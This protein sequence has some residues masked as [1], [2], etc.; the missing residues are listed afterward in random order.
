MKHFLSV[1]LAAL[2]LLA[3]LSGSVLA[4]P[5]SDSATALTGTRVKSLSFTIPVPA[6]QTPAAL[7]LSAPDYLA[8]ELSW[9]CNGAPMSD[10]APFADGN[11]YQ[12]IIELSALNGYTF[13]GSFVIT[14]NDQTVPSFGTAERR[15][16]LVDFLLSAG[17]CVQ[18]FDPFSD[19]KLSDYFYN[20]VLWAYTSDP[21]IT[22]GL[23]ATEFG[24]AAS[25]TRGQVVTFLWR[26]CGCPEP[27]TAENPFTDVKPTEYW[28]KPILWAVEQGIT[29]GTSATT[30]SPAATCTNAHILTFLWRAMGQP[31]KTENPQSWYADA[32]NWAEKNGLLTGTCTGTLDTA[33]DC[34][35]CNVVEYLYR[36]SSEK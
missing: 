20:A 9:Y 12:L 8:M 27:K 5:S 7:Q 17:K 22:T 10:T 13:D 16:A 18:R 4:E 1:C 32:L 14:V 19:V 30:F 36:C 31:G 11:S 2:L 34:P 21:Q 29:A 24:P 26:A 6:G 35:R 28:Y 3:L 25:C 23:S 33:A 15:E